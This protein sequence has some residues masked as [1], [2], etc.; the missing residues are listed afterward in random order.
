MTLLDTDMK[1]NTILPNNF[2]PYDKPGQMKRQS[3]HKVK[4][5][6]GQYTGYEEG[7][8]LSILRDTVRESKYWIL[9]KF[10]IENR[11]IVESER[12][13][14][15]FQLHKILSEYETLQKKMNQEYLKTVTK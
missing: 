4:N 10:K 14:C 12:I 2:D 11:Q 7:E 8:M 6:I 13:D 3:S 15:D 9:A 1:T 5:L